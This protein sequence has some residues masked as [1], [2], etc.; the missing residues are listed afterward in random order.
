MVEFSLSK[1]ICGW[2]NSYKKSKCVWRWHED[3][4]PTFVYLVGDN[5]H[6]C[7]V[8]ITSHMRQEETIAY[9][10]L[11]TLSFAVLPSKSFTSQLFFL[12]FDY[13]IFYLIIMSFDVFSSFLF[14]FF[15]FGD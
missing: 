5:Q 2:L 6:I 12:L 1:S 10:R 4:S 11:Q 7:E 13:K 8:H 14:V 3:F 15:A 9:L